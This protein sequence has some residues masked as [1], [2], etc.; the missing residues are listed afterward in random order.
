MTFNDL[1]SIVCI[2]AIPL[3]VFE[4]LYNFCVSFL[5]HRFFNCIL[6]YLYMAL[7]YYEKTK[8]CNYNIY[9][10]Y[11]HKGL[12]ILYMLMHNFF[13]KDLNT[14]I[15]LRHFMYRSIYLLCIQYRGYDALKY[16][17]VKMKCN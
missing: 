3:I 6:Y 11:L 7:S 13:P 10:I 4:E 12:H 17:K 8:F 9:E 16:K 14:I 1:A 15:S 2:C 5:H